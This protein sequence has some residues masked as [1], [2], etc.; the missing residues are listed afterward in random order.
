LS[1]RHVK[2][3]SDLNNAGFKINDKKSCWIPS[4]TV[5]WLGIILDSDKNIFEVPADKLSRLKN[6]IFKNL[7]YRYSCSPR[8]LAKTVGKITSLYHA[9]G[10]LVYIM[11][12]NTTRWI[13]EGVSWSYREVIPESVVNELQFWFRN[14]DII[15][16]KP[17]VKELTR[18]THIVYS[19]ASASG[20]GA[21]VTTKPDLDMVHYWQ[22]YEKNASSTWRELKTVALFLNLH[23]NTFAGTAVTWYT[24]NQAVPIITYKGS[25]KTDL[26]QLALEIYKICLVKDIDLSLY[27]VPREENQIA[28]DLSKIEDTEDWQVQRSIFEFL[29][30]R[31]GTF[32]LD[33]FASNLSRK[34]DFFFSKYWC[35][36]S[37]GVDAF[38]YSWKNETLWL[39]PPPRLIPKVI[40]HAKK[41]HAKGLLI[42]PRWQ[43]ATFWPLIWDGNCW[44]A[45]LKLMLEYNKPAN[46]FSRGPFGNNVF[47]EEQFASNVLVFEIDF[48]NA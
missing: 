40:F 7:K 1:L 3:G 17:L 23:E 31:Y 5:K 12:K 34:T 28:D 33:A 9:Y 27:W 38:S 44:A 46:F 4:K 8:E 20:C 10:G 35:E 45:G 48:T 15:I 6:A 18:L 25:M 2:C 14:L 39:V 21:Y 47:C 29:Q 11:T 13:S 26:N 30:K 16:R 24:D 22:T 42:L 32:T 41:C 43:S 36:G 19:D 37:S